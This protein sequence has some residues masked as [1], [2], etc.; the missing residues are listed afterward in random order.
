MVF[1]K[2]LET[3]FQVYQNT[4]LSAGISPPDGRIQAILARDFSAKLYKCQEV[5]KAKLEMFQNQEGAR[6]FWIFCAAVIDET[7]NGNISVGSDNPP[8]SHF[9]EL[10]ASIVRLYCMKL[11]EMNGEDFS[12]DVSGDNPK[13][14]RN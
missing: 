10:L 6:A 8:P 1:L 12:L 5:E 4:A 14:E 9:V 11:I 2:E 13:P 3:Q 7:K